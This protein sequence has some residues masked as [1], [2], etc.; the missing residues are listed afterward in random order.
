[1]NN[2]DMMHGCIDLHIHTNYS[3]GSYSI[4]EIINKAE[5]IGLKAISITDHDS[6]AA[7]L[8]IDF[9]NERPLVQIINGIELTASN[10]EDKE[11]HILGYG[12]NP[13]EPRLN[14][15]LSKIK[16][17]KFQRST[18][19]IRMLNEKNI[20]VTLAE[21]IDEG[22]V[23]NTFGITQILKKKK[24]WDYVVSEH[25]DMFEGNGQIRLSKNLISI[26]CAIE[27]ITQAGGKA[28]LAHPNTVSSNHEVQ[29]EFI[30]KYARKG[31]WGVECYNSKN[32]INPDK[33]LT[34]IVKKLN[35]HI[36][37]GSD[38][39]GKSLPDVQIGT[40]KGDM[41]IPFNIL[42]QMDL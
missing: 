19:V 14:K 41:R 30:K 24:L 26:E 23:V 29:I 6:V 2:K 25:S 10:N 4:H 42:E 32:L 20:P 28:F 15:Y 3:D 9:I 33:H 11:I 1:M 12:I 7:L 37:G 35:L 13:Y 39:H 18:N 16:N 31:L 21:I 8:D 38:F 27:I 40:G 5:D 34:E 22:Y 36:S 17:E